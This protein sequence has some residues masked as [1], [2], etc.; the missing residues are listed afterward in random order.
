MTNKLILQIKIFVYNKC[1]A[2]PVEFI[3]EYLLK[4][5]L[6][7]IIKRKKK[8]KVLFV[9][10]DLQTWK[11]EQLYVQMLKNNRLIPILG[12]TAS[13]ETLGD[14]KKLVSYCERKGYSY[15]WIKPNQRLSKQ[16]KSDIV[17]FPKPYS[18]TIHIKHYIPYNIFTLYI[19]VNYGAFAMVVDWWGNERYIQHCWKVFF[20]NAYSM[21][22][23]SKLMNNRGKNL[24][25]TGL[26]Y[27]E[28]YLQPKEKFNNPWKNKDSRKRIIYAPHHT[29][30]TLFAKGIHYSTFLE[31]GE[32]V[33]ELAKR[34]SDKCYFAFKPHP[35]LYKKLQRYWKKDRVD[36]YYH[37]W[38]ELENAQLEDGDYIGLFKHSDAMIHD[39]CSFMIEYHYSHKPALY[40]MNDENMDD[41]LTFLGKQAR[42]M[43][44]KAFDKTD[45]DRFI[46]NVIVDIDPLKN[47]RDAFY[48]QYLV[49]PEGSSACD[50]IIKSIT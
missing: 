4:P 9:L 25:S 35:L 16:I 38:E 37:A 26:P 20:D 48:E 49:P 42:K 41:N 21:R 22:Q 3:Y 50:N 17:L 13:T 47:E 30:G 18:S 31:Y 10:S 7:F 28:V 43:H 45:I 32:Y 40:L 34:Y 44:Y 36:A 14:E 27:M 29:I 33:L 46:D 5:I 12:I 6:I 8:I 1:F 11:S 19:Y 39:C 2:E 24:V 15:I 23:Y